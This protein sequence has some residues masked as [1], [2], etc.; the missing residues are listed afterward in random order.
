VKSFSEGIF[1]RVGIRWPHRSNVASAVIILFAGLILGLLIL[2]LGPISLPFVIFV[3]LLLPWLIEE[4]FRL[5]ICLII[6]WPIFTLYIRIPLPAGVPDLSY[7]RALVVLLLCVVLLEALLSKR[8]LLKV[9]PLDILIIVYVIEQIITRLSVVWFGGVGYVD[10]NGFL[11][12]IL[13][14]VMLYWLV[15]NLLVSR[16]HLKWLLYALVIASLFVCLTGLFEQAVGARIFKASISLGGSEEVYQWQDTQGGLRAAGALG[17]PAIYG[18]V[19]GIGSLAGLCCLSLVKQKPI[20]VALLATI[21]V[22][23]YGVLASYT[24]SAW[25]SVFVVLFAAQFL[26][27]GFWKKTLPTITLGLLL[28]I[29]IWNVVPDSSKIVQR[30]LTTKTIDQRIDIYSIGL[31]RF[32]EKPILGWGSGALNIFD[33]AGAGIISHNIYLTFL[34]DGGAALFLSFF[35][36]IGYLLIRS[37][38][39]YR[40]TEKGSLER[41]TLVAMTGSILIYLLSGMAL[42]LRYF[43][44]F[45]ALFWICAGVI[46]CLGERFCSARTAS[47]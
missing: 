22:L 10:L 31:E 13:I 38:R 37:I 47:E 5:F 25:L 24:R 1:P 42:E 20:Q 15:K 43:G 19:L 6:T 11:D 7:D 12:V 18:A 34:V 16:A 2:V 35:A 41:N 21:G 28:L 23:L 27:N 3:I 4:P 44:Y 39:I 8:R 9:T 36:V 14:P 32:Q 40:I 29:T 46:D 30:A 17:N 26:I 33:L 45:N